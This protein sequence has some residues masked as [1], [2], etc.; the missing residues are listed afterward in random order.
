MEC[1]MNIV[2]HKL[3][4]TG[5]GQAG[6]R[7]RLSSDHRSSA[8]AST[9][10][11]SLGLALGPAVSTGIARFS[12]GLTLPAMRQDLAW[13]Y[14]EAGWINTANAI[15]YL[16]G[17]LLALKFVPKFGPRRLFVAG[18]ILTTLALFAS[19]LTRDFW[20]L[21]VWRVL[22]GVGGA[23]AF[24]AGGAMVSTLFKAQPWRNT[25]AIAIY[26]GGVGFG[27]LLTGLAVP[28]ILECFGIAAWPTAWLMLAGVSAIAAVPAIAA[29]QIIR[30]S[31]QS[32]GGGLGG[33]L[34][35]GSM[36][37]ALLG[38]FFF[39]VGY[40][41]YITF[42]IAWMRLQGADVSLVIATWCVLGIAVMVSPWPW[43]PILTAAKGGEALALASVATGFG[44]LLPLLVPG[45]TGLLLSAAIFGVSFVTAPTSITAFTRK[46]LPE[47]LWGSS[48]ALF[49]TVFAAGQT[50]GPIAAGI[51]AD[52]TDRLS[53][54]LI[55]AA[56]TLFVAAAVSRLQ[57]SLKA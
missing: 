34:P 44:T 39:S 26:A 7:K 49:T 16:I 9:W 43:A 40:I 33:L 45:S 23:H 27:I 29:A 48:L 2:N 4:L 47:A 53:P 37:P 36:R 35:I 51:M 1:K 6:A 18:M 55:A 12:Y 31:P 42:L 38:Y 20:C 56:L 25:M 8:P 52:A 14:T 19:G 28:L 15:G 54:G 46:N 57:A 5:A 30:L 11:I 17:S 32:N 41:V 24:V 10:L 3:A 50:L 21:S 13:T 22:A